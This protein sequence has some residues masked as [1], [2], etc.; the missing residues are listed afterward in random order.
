MTKDRDVIVGRGRGGTFEKITLGGTILGILIPFAILTTLRLMLIG[1][2]TVVVLMIG[3][4]AGGLIGLGTG[5]YVFVRCWQQ[6]FVKR[7][8]LTVG[9]FC[10][11]FILILVAIFDYWPAIVD[12][13]WS[14]AEMLVSWFGKPWRPVNAFVVALRLFFIFALPIAVWTPYSWVEWAFKME[15]KW[16]KFRETPFATADPGSVK[17]GGISATKKSAKGEDDDKDE[18]VIVPAPRIEGN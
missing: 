17:D 7:P 18:F 12:W 15:L 9:A 3:R 13:R 5:V 14:G 8:E 11:S 2:G 10:L 6:K 16:P 4:Y 1:I